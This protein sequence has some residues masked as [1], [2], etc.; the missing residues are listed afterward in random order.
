MSY[1][2]ELTPPVAKYCP[3][4]QAEQNKTHRAR[5]S[6]PFPTLRRRLLW[7]PS[8][9]RKAYGHPDQPRAG[10]LTKCPHHAIYQHHRRAQSIYHPDTQRPLRSWSDGGP[11]MIRGWS[12]GGPRN[13]GPP[14]EGRRIGNGA[15][16]GASPSRRARHIHPPPSIRLPIEE[17]VVSLQC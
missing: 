7:H 3:N 16:N 2:L 8:R 10:P 13:G 6:T 5:H 11:G 9:G 15:E 4:R 14:S 17:K 12:D 1:F